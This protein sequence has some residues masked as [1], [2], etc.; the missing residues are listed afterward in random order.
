MFCYACVEFWVQSW[1]ARDRKG[2]RSIGEGRING[3]VEIEAR[4]KRMCFYKLFSF[5]CIQIL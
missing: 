1:T 2:R 4:E 5:V 3:L